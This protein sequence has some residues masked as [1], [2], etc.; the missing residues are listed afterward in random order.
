LAV[1]ENDSG[2]IILL[3]SETNSFKKL[4]DWRVLELILDNLNF[5]W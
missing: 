4:I 2:Y 1:K 3:G 5:V